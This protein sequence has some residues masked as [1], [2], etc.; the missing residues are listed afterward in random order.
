MLLQ[1]RLWDC[2]V[3]PEVMLTRVTLASYGQPFAANKLTRK[4]DVSIPL[5]VKTETAPSMDG[6][7][8][9]FPGKDCDF[10]P[11]TLL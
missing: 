4:Q 10:Y 6:S 3:S 9:T 5:A 2:Y 7:R 8:F 11:E 1:V